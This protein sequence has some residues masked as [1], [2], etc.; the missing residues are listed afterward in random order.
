MWS[1]CIA[2]RSYLLTRGRGLLRVVEECKT[3]ALRKDL[4]FSLAGQN[5]ICPSFM[6]FSISS[7]N[8]DAGLFC[9]VL[10]IGWFS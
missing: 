6:N 3:V 8:L 1:R 9:G 5:S 10:K 2:N 7:W 4:S